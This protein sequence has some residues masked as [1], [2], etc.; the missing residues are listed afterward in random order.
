MAQID[1]RLEK[2]GQPLGDDDLEPFTRVLYASYQAL[3]AATS[4]GP[5]DACR[6][7]AERSAASSRGTTHC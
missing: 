2:L 3:T 1:A 5:S 6:R 4:A 7:S